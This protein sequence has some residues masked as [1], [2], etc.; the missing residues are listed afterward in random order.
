MVNLY[1]YIVISLMSLST[2]YLDFKLK[3]QIDLML[4]AFSQFYVWLF[5]VFSTIF[6]ADYFFIAH[7]YV[8]EAPLSEFSWCVGGISA[9]C[10][11]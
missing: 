6:V 1:G 11:V 10:R 9:Y 4:C 2:E 3:V 5:L 8:L 7:Q